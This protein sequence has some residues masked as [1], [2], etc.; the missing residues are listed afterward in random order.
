MLLNIS[1]IISRQ[2]RITDAAI[3]FYCN[4]L[5]RN[6]TDHNNVTKRKFGVLAALQ[7]LNK[8]IQA[9]D[10]ISCM[11]H[12]YYINQYNREDAKFTKPFTF[13]C[14]SVDLLIALVETIGKMAEEM[15][16]VTAMASVNGI[17]AQVQNDPWCKQFLAN[18]S[19]AETL[20]ANH[21]LEYH[22]HQK[23]FRNLSANL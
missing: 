6:S 20:I 13:V 9:G 8:W 2:R 19:Y 11:I 12:D 4:S 10:M 15:V 14:S 1:Q 18:C 3:N 21:P 17:W 22:V 7:Q 23:T 5:D 16:R